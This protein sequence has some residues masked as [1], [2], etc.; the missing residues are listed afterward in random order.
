MNIRIN[1]PKNVRLIIDIML[2][3]GYEA[4]L[5]GGCV[6]DCILGKEPK[7]WDITT[8]AKPLEIVALFDKVI[9]TG[10]K[11][12]TVTII[13]DKESYEI[14]TYRS[15]GEY[16][17]NRH[18]KEVKFVSSL[19]EDL[20]RR[21]FTINSMAYNEINGL[22]DYFNGV[23]DL[24]RKVIKTVGDPKKRFNEDALRMLRAIRFS[25]QLDFDIDRLTLNSIK[26]LKDNIKNISKERIR[27]EF[28]KIL[29][30]N[31][32]KIETLRECGILEYIVPGISKIY[33][34]NQ[35][36]SYH[37]QDLYNHTI[38]ATEMV[39]PKIYLKLSMLFH[40]FGRTCI[41]KTD[42]NG[43][44][45]YCSYSKE[46]SRMASEILKYLKYDNDILNKV[47]ILVQY[48]DYIMEN[49]VSI[50]K[51]LSK[52]G[53]DLFKD[54]IKIQRA[55]IL[56]QDSKYSR[57]HLINLAEAESILNEIIDNDE[58]FTLKNLKINGGDL[59]S[60]GFNKGKEIGEVLN[61]LL[62]IVIENPKW[63]EKQELIKLAM[64]R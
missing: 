60:L 40:E 37:L 58:C 55:D 21:D 23:E 32:R 62:D 39:E 46:S 56:A 47:I 61:Y 28:N 1:I 50:K 27:E 3:N 42:E 30:N 18:P 16:E 57:K 22:V 54:L 6:R 53:I 48:H 13:L 43:I 9:L 34:F 11:H 10:L 33:N 5:V 29:L 25:A 19:K 52:I 64:K 41:R 36:S 15:D 12:G 45:H 17:D 4:Y 14:T 59:L 49:K 63:N 26:E 31:P 38:I 20:A 7:D 35:N 51:L 2:K 44:S 8:N 24:C